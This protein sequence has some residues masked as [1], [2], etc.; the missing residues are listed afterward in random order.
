MICAQAEDHVNRVDVN[1][2]NALGP[3]AEAEGDAAIFRDLRMK[4][5]IDTADLAGHTTRRYR[6]GS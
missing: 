4:I 3:L 1:N 2:L 5:F 6:P